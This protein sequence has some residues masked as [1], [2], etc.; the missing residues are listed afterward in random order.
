V[1]KLRPGER[2]DYREDDDHARARPC[3]PGLA[4]RLP[5]AIGG[6]PLGQ[7]AHRAVKLVV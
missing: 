4:L 5:G 1:P 2:A 3:S 7:F 6:R